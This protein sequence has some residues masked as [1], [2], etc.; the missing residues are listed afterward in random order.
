MDYLLYVRFINDVQTA[1]DAMQISF[2]T[3]VVSWVILGLLL[4]MLVFAYP[5][6]RG[7][8]HDSFEWTH[9]FLGWTA[10]TLVWAQVVLFINDGRKP[11]EKL[12]HACKHDVAFWLQ[13]IITLSIILPWLRLRKVNVRA[14][15]LSKHATRL[16]FNYS[17]SFYFHRAFNH[18][19]S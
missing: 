19:G 6:M 2:A 17:T 9:R 16:Y 7:K 12:P 8:F 5:T 10:L 3:V 13:S 1:A 14:V 11:G 18:V 15:T 4:V